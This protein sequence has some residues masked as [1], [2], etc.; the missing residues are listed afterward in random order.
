[1]MNDK[2]TIS[3]I[4]IAVGSDN[5]I[6]DISANGQ[7]QYVTLD[8]LK[9]IWNDI[10]DG[11]RADIEYINAEVSDDFVICCLTVSQG[12]GGIVFVWDTDKQ[13]I[14]HYS[15]GKYA[16]RAVI[17]DNKVYVLR[18][19]SYW[20][21]TAHL[22]LDYCDFGTMAEDNSTVTI[23]LDENT[24]Q[25]L[26]NNLADYIIEFDDNNIPIVK[27]K[28]KKYKLIGKDGKPYLSDTKGTFGGHSD[29][30]I[31]GRLDCPSAIRYIAKGQYVKHRVF[32]ADEETAI[33]AG[34]RPCAVCMR[35]KY[36]LWKEGQGK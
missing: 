9:E 8:M 4:N 25:N 21:V 30:K 23:S 14:V 22:E 6:M 28:G 15:D 35:H 19:V 12:Q 32:F 11:N 20:G 13:K 26:T 16:V 7:H 18:V 10:A 31:Y 17:N 36:I 5:T 1:M 33:A 34:Y 24:S 27:I 3:P 29:S 2:S